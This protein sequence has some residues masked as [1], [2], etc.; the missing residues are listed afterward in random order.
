LQLLYLNGCADISIGTGTAAPSPSD[1]PTVLQ[2]Q[3]H[4]DEER[5]AMLEIVS[6]FAHDYGLTDFKKKA[7]TNFGSRMMRLWSDVAYDDEFC[8]E[9]VKSNDA[10]SAFTVTPEA[11]DGIETLTRKKRRG[12]KK[13]TLQEPQSGWGALDDFFN[14]FDLKAPLP[15]RPDAIPRQPV[16]DEGILILEVLD[17]SGYDIGY[18]GAFTRS[19]DG[20]RIIELCKRLEIEF[21]IKVGC[22][23]R[24]VE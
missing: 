11:N 16:V 18:Y 13:V 21:S 12:I 22:E 15:Y 6:K 17:H 9:I 20:K 19:S 7:R 10:W 3:S 24:R 14:E 23:H 5:V 8:I 2:T 4:L 1:S